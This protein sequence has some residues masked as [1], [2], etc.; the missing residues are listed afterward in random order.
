M[1]DVRSYIK[2]FDS[3][4]SGKLTKQVKC[5]ELLPEIDIDSLLETK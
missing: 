2:K 4:V 3:K 5:F 1:G